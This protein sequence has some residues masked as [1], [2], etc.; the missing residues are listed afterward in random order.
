MVSHPPPL[1]WRHSVRCFKG[2]KAA[3]RNLLNGVIVDLFFNCRIRQ[4]PDSLGELGG[5]LGQA[6]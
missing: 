3:S 2:I 5:Q 6:T 4:V 1:F